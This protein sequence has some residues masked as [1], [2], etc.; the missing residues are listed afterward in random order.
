[1]IK[2]NVLCLDI[3]LKN[4]MYFTQIIAPTNDLFNQDLLTA[5]PRVYGRCS[6]ANKRLFTGIRRINIAVND[7]LNRWQTKSKVTLSSTLLLVRCFCLSKCK[8]YVYVNICLT[9]DFSTQKTFSVLYTCQSYIVICIISLIHYLSTT[10][11]N[12][13]NYL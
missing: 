12:K 8:S 4:K 5:Y 9:I 2:L 7:H 11:L 3:V 10:I 1:M 13:C 6:L